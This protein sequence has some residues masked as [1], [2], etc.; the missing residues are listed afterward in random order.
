M[1]IISVVRLITLMLNVVYGGYRYAHCHYGECR[2]VA[3][4]EYY[5]APLRV[6]P[7]LISTP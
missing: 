2:Y 7:D 3:F 6:S 4:H 5:S 1:V